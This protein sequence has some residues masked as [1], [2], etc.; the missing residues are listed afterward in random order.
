MIQR[1]QTLYLLLS[2]LLVATLFFVPLADL[3]GKDGLL[4]QFTLAGLVSGSSMAH[5]KL[6]QL[7]LAGLVVGFC[8]L[9]ILLYRNRGL[10]IKVAYFTIFL[11]VGLLSLLFFSLLKSSEAIGASYSLKIFFTFPAIA[12]ILVYMAIRGMVK[13][14]NLVKSIDRIR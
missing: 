2:T 13:D 5:S 1:I 11:L 3:T 10:Q 9:S 14:D 4:Y 7:V 6:P 8:I 12:V